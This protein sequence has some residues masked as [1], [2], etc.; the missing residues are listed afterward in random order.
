MDFTTNS[1]QPDVQPRSSF[2]SEPA[3]TPAPKG[4]GHHGV[5]NNGNGMNNNLLRWAGGALVVVV[6][7]LIGAALGLFFTYN[8]NANSE[9][10]LIDT[11]KLQAVFLTNN[12]VYF[13]NVTSVNSHYLT[14]QG[15]YYL[16]SDSTT[17]AA[18]NSNVSLVKLGCELHRPYDAMV[19]NQ[20]QV[21]FIENL[22]PDG[23]V[24]K[25]VAQYQSANPNGQTCSNTTTNS[26][27]SSTVQ[28][29]S[30]TNNTTTN[31][32][33]TTNSTTNSTSNSTTGQ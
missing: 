19:I 22:Q 24:A 28:G 7:L 13:G 29:T 33:S 6:A 32:N 30:T 17:T 10:N 18:S 23:Q 12:Q 16:Q 4:R 14:L 5:T 11:S 1:Q 8:P 20:N 25:A 2:Q 3:T 31:N 27:D 9:S 26:A 21:T 15:I